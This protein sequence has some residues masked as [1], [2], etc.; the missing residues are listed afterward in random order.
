MKLRVILKIMIRTGQI[1]ATK[2]TFNQSD[3]DR[4]A[5]LSGDD[6]PIHVDPAYAAR[7]KFGHTVAH[8]MFLYSHVCAALNK[9]LSGVVQLEQ[10][11]MFPNPTFV[12]EEIMISLKMVDE[13]V[14][15][16]LELETV[17][18]RPDGN[19]GLQGRTWVVGERLSVSGERYAESRAFGVD[20][21][22][23]SYKGLRV[24]QQVSERR[25]FTAADL[26][27]YGALVGDAN[28]RYL[29]AGGNVPGGLL[30]GMFSDLL[31]TR[32]PGRGTNWLKQQLIFPRVAR[33]GEEITA[34]VSI[35]RIRPPKALVNLRTTCTNPAGEFVCTGE[36]LVLVNELEQVNEN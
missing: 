26:A 36:S 21:Q 15:G 3:F 30:G 23:I 1:H 28:P 27:G 22:G 32:L 14:D 29:A 5:V 9:L 35:T 4:F 34:V 6:N 10:E 20:D 19:V 7:T 33:V 13:D 16:I 25:T 24:G 8:G 17:L 2:L 12:D 18:T 11:M 31:G